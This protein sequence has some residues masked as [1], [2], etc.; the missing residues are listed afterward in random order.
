MRSRYAA[1]STGNEAY[2]LKSWHPSKRP[3]TLNLA[4]Q[5]NIKWVDLKVI[6]HQS[7]N[8]HA[9]V[10]FITKYKLNGK[11]EKIHERSRFVREQ[12]R[13]LYVDGDNIT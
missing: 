10:E 12:G 6:D 9:E 5:R 13:W 8:D 1:F 3:E 7:Q 2:L 11:A 4:E